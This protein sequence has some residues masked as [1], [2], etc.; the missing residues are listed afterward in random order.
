MPDESK[1]N[2]DDWKNASNQL[3]VS[4]SKMSIFK[5]HTFDVRGHFIEDDVTGSEN[6]DGNVTMYYTASDNTWRIGSTTTGT[7]IV[8]GC[9]FILT[10]GSP[11]SGV[12]SQFRFEWK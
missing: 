11:G 3:T 2:P 1:D 4:V 12:R 6:Y 5:D 9:T 10:A 8:D 7:V